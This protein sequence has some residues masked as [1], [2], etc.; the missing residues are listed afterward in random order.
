MLKDQYGKNV[1]TDLVALPSFSSLTE[2][3]TKIVFNAKW[4]ECEGV[5]LASWKKLG[6]LS[7]IQPEDCGVKINNQSVIFRVAD[8][9]KR[10]NE[11]DGFCN[12]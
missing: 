2:A 10:G 1:P 9:L 12:A 4:Y 7:E 8:A 11:E 3:E 5:L 6:G